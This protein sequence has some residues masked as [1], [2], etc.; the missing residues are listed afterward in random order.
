MEKGK[1]AK[2][3]RNFMYEQQV[4]HLPNN[5]SVD[6]I[7]NQVEQNL[8]PK[9]MACILHDKDLKDDNKTP[10]EAHI[11]MMLQFEN[12]RSVNQVAKD[13][14]DNPQQL[15]VWKGNVENGFSYLVHATDN[16][17]HKHQYSCDEVRANFD[18]PAFIQ[19][20]S[21]KV[22]KIDGISNAN[23]INGMLD[24]I[25]TGD[26]TLEEAK[27]QLTGSVYAKYGDK[28]KKHTNYISKEVRIF[29]III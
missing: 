3:C 25:A 22:S 9:R 16:S 24:L 18:Y 17:R 12:A 6:D 21:K 2:K 7:Y 13:I 20:I 27:A 26:M 29:C 11:H 8:K 14:G 4:S 15:E 10:A 1:Q 23:K 28:L 19:E 5:M